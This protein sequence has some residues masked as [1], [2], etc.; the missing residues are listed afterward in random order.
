MLRVLT[1]GSMATTTLMWRQRLSSWASHKGDQQ[2]LKQQCP[3]PRPQLLIY[4]IWVGMVVPRSSASDASVH[5]GADPLFCRWARAAELAST[6]G[7]SCLARVSWFI[8]FYESDIV[9]TNA[10]RGQSVDQ[11]SSPRNSP[12]REVWIHPHSRKLGGAYV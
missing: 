6:L 8:A 2:N 4:F 5:Q 11:C 10:E 9:F 7:L 12:F 1:L 3:G